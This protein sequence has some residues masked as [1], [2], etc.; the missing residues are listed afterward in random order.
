MFRK[1]RDLGTGFG[2]TVILV[3]TFFFLTAGLYISQGPSFGASAHK[4]TVTHIL[5][6]SF[7]P[8][9]SQE[10]IDAVS[11]PICKSP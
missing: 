6:V 1:A 2:C 9:A 10:T 8:S 5:L 7:K 4:M 11:S 3:A